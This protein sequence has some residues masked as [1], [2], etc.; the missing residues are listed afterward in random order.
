MLW[1]ARLDQGGFCHWYGLAVLV[2]ARWEIAH[3][4]DWPDTPGMGFRRERLVSTPFR[5]QNPGL[6]KNQVDANAL[7]QQLAFHMDCLP[8]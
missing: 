2:A 5:P 8:A 7:P 4:L 3:E 6:F 1:P